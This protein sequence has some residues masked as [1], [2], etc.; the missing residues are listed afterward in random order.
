MNVLEGGDCRIELF[1]DFD[2]VHTSGI[3]LHSPVLTTGYFDS[4][5]DET[6]LTALTAASSRNRVARN[7]DLIDESAF[8]VSSFASPFPRARCRPGHPGARQAEQGS[9]K[10][11]R[12]AGIDEPRWVLTFWF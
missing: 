7:R 1:Q 4:F 5:A 11:G 6:L 2:A 12:P 9:G 10:P 3:P 8:I